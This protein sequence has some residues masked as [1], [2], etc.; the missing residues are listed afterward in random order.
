MSGLTISNGIIA[1]LV[2]P[3]SPIYPVATS[4]TILMIAYG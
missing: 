1:S 2:L 4:I 3:L